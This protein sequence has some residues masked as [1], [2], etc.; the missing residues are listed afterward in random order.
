VRKLVIVLIAALVVVAAVGV[1]LGWLLRYR[2]LEV[3]AWS[4]RLALRH[5]GLTR[6]TVASPAGPQTVW[7]GGRGPVMVLLHGAG[8][9]AGTWYRVV[10]ELIKDFTLVVP[11]LAGHGSSAPSSGPIDVRAV[12]DGVEADIRDLAGGR[13]A[14]LVGNSLGAWIAT[15]VAR[16]HPDWIERLVLVDGG[17]LRGANVHAIVLP[18]NRAQAR[19]AVAQT[20]DP[21]SPPVPDFVLDDIVRQAKVGPLARFASTAFSME[22]FVLSE[23]ELHEIEAPV[24]IIWGASDRLM[25]SDYAE[26]M[27][28]AFPH[29]SLLR[30]DHCGH[31][32]QIE[33]PDR[34]LAALKL[35]VAP[36]VE[37]PG[38]STGAP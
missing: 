3:F 25:P 17:A 30:I 20:R 21:G 34:L 27:L 28:G 31:I 6:V 1:W 14:T 11:D 22:Q 12:L 38:S 19:E 4:S 33:C 18:A 13:K 5:A 26:R 9:Q 37:A 15:L 29:A 35:T 23:D 24:V 7:H 32:P 16:R 8:D 10:P 2:P 36:H